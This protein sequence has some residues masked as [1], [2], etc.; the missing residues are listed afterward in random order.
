MAS[1]T[2][3][4]VDTAGSERDEASTDTST[5]FEEGELRT[6]PAPQNNLLRTRTGSG[7][8]T[9]NDLDLEDG[10]LAELIRTLSRRTA[11]SREGKPRDPLD[12]DDPNFS[13]ESFL[14]HMLAKHEEEDGV[15]DMSS[16]ASLGFSNVT[17]KGAGSSATFQPTVATLFYGPFLKLF[18]RLRGRKEPV[19]E[20]LHGISGVVREGEMLL[21]LGRPGAG[22]STL[23]KTLAGMTEGYVGWDGKVGYNGVSSKTIAKRF[24][25]DVVYNPEVDIHFP[26]LSVEQTLSFAAKTHTPRNRGDGVTREQFVEKMVLL[27]ATVFGLRHTLKTKV[28]NDFVRGVSGGERKRVSIAESLATRASVGFWDNSTRGLDASTSL[29]FAQALRVATNLVRNVAVVAIYQAGENLTNV[30]DKVTVLYLGHQIYYGTL[31]EAKP[32]FENMGFVCGPRQTTAD[33]LTAITDPQGRVVKEGWESRAPRTPEEFSEIWRKS[34]GYRRLQ[35]ELEEYWTEHSDP[36]AAIKNFEE[37]Q[38]ALKSK[39]AHKKSPYLLSVGQQIQVTITRAYQRVWGDKAFLFANAFSAIFVSLINGSVF[40]NTTSET[41]GFFSKGGVLFFAVLF[42]ALSSMAEIPTLYSQRPIVQKQKS[43]AMYHPFTEALASFFADWPIKFV[44]STCFNLILYFMTGLK[45]E[46][47]PFFIYFLF[48]Y[49]TTLCMSGFFRTVAASTKRVETALSIGG[50][51]VLALVVYTGY[52]IPRPSMHPWFKWISYIN[53]LAY[54]FEALMANEFHGRQS[55][56]SQNS[57][58]P[59]GPGYESVS[60]NSKVC[61]VTGALPGELTVSGD[62]YIWATFQYSYAHIWRNLGIIIGFWIFFIFTS[63]LATELNSPP[64]SQGEFLIFKRGQAPEHIKKAVKEKKA[65]DVEDAEGG[66]VTVAEKNQDDHEAEMDG[67][68]KSKDIF[69]W[70]NLTYHVTIPGGENRRLLD[71]IMGYVKP[72]TLTALVGESGAGKTTL[73]NALAQRLET[74]V[75]SGNMNVNGSPVDHSFQRRT[76]YV[77]QQDL[78]LA[79]STVREALR[80]S[81]LLRQ[82]K[83]VSTE[84]KYDYVEKVIRLLEMDDYAEAVIGVPGEGLNVEQRKRTTIGVELV[85]KP[86]LLLFLDEPTSGLDSQSAWSIVCLLRKLAAHGQAIL[87][88]IHQPSAIL[89]EQFDRLLLLRKGGQTVYFGDIGRNSE[90]LVKYFEGNGAAKCDPKANPAEYI[91][92]VIG[93]GATAHATKDW[94]DVWLNSREYV[95]TEREIAELQREYG[96]QHRGEEHTTADQATF[97]T[98]WLTQ[99]IQVQK[100]ILQLYWRSPVYITGKLTLNIF[101]GLFMG[102]TFYKEDATVQGM[103]NR[104]FAIFMSTVLSTALMHQIQPRFI[105]LSEL[106]SVREKPSKMYHW[107]TFVASLVLIEIPYNFV[108]GTLFFLPWYFA[109]GFWKGAENQANRGGYMYY[110]FLLFQMYFSTFGQAIG[111]LSPNE[112]TASALTTLLFT[113][114]ILFNGVLQPVSQ[115][116]KF[117]HWMY[118]LSPFTY[119]IGG[120]MGNA[121]HDLKIKCTSAETNYFSLPSG[122][123]GTCADYAGPYVKATMGYLVNPEARDED[124]GFCRYDTGDQYLATINIKYD[125]RWRNAN[126]LWAYIVFNAVLVFVFFYLTRVAHFKNPIAALAAKKSKKPI[127]TSVEKEGEKVVYDERSAGIALAPEPEQLAGGVPPTGEA[128]VTAQGTR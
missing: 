92:D 15:P 30:F 19:R 116:V 55:K 41:N 51:S 75:V 44:N 5:I 102:F 100:R 28:G 50:V 117:W 32:Y 18:E 86:A 67:V 127:E 22:C 104:M 23:L 46:A 1:P 115:L 47:A 34:D 62:N 59:N 54:G 83:E 29:E 7:T 94:H 12:V 11:Q 98:S 39:R 125:Q 3:D 24:R 97:A 118:H 37:R 43:Y 74:G 68:A 121:V 95:N 112:E 81:A 85:A 48:T 107:S 122:F 72:G 45:R 76:G 80:F 64:T 78:H 69:T 96:S 108:C 71:N 79:E 9:L 26:H 8:F 10:Q 70:Q 66:A 105:T 31:T 20:I 91:L 56:C 87:C 84:E 6:R 90:T 101:A 99:Y 63:A 4:R 40:V 60:G 114:V 65:G 49:I 106:F 16:K 57:I 14:R 27:L 53:P 58:I 36:Q 126:L 35:Q 42:N 61:A 119:L 124:C 128:A 89:F 110:V 38:Q 113:F 120:Y 88:T 13:L 111:A 73:L 17:V 77:Q 21:V 25:G 82:P 2:P 109:V 123:D 93:A 103:Q 33:F 52:V